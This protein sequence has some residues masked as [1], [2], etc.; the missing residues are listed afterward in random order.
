[1][2]RWFL[3]ALLLLSA[4]LVG[5]WAVAQPPRDPATFCCDHLFYRAMSANWVRV[6]RPDLQIVPPASGLAADAALTRQAPYTYRVL[7]PFLAGLL[8]GEVGAWLLTAA[9]LI[10][11]ATG[12][13]WLAA[14][15]SGQPAAGFGAAVVFA[16][17][18]TVA[19]NLADP[20]LVDPLLWAL[21]AGAGVLTW[22]RQWGAALLLGAA[23]L[24]TK[25]L[26]LAFLPGLVWWAARTDR[27]R[28]GWV[29]GGA[30]LLAGAYL[31]ARA[32][33]PVG[34]V[35]YTLATAWVGLALAPLAL[36]L[37]ALSCGGVLLAALPGRLRR[38]PAF[39]G[40][41]VPLAAAALLSTLFATNRERALIFA[42]PAVLLVV[43]GARGL[44]PSRRLAPVA[45]WLAVAGLLALHAPYGPVLLA[46]VA[47]VLLLDGAAWAH[48]RRP[49]P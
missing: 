2:P 37:L 25:E 9:S 23:G 42:L 14:A 43:L 36:A 47:S 33:V 49:R 6:T 35:P 13:G 45:V 31:A 27:P 12:F 3:P 46:G 18:P 10:A 20:W 7:A 38:A 41:W 17:T 24:L 21:L 8:G 39:A 34:G 28:A 44:S 11:A 22:R 29:A 40:V 16:G 32:L 19:A 30:A 4:A 15:T 1:M 26:M 48:V 5:G